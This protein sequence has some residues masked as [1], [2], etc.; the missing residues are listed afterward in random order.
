[1]GKHGQELVF[2]MVK[3]CYSFCLIVCLPLQTATFSDVSNVALN[4]VAL[5]H[6]IDITDKFDFDRL[7]VPG[8][9][10]QVLVTNI[11]LGLQF[12]ESGFVLLS[13]SEHTDLPDFLSHDLGM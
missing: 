10:R 11:A 2:T 13:V 9:E 12:A 7:P 5:V 3:F 1:M 6:L 8:F 4:I